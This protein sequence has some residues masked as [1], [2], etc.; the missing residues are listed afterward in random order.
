MTTSSE[1]RPVAAT[2][3]SEVEVSFVLACGGDIAGLV[4]ALT[5]ISAWSTANEDVSMELVLV[6]RDAH[7]L[8][9]AVQD[10]SGAPIRTLHV[11]APATAEE[12]LALGT[13]VAVGRELVSLAIGVNEAVVGAA[14]I[15]ESATAAKS[16]RV[17][18]MTR[19]VNEARGRAEWRPARW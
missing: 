19:S 5:Q 17:I 4:E 1:L 15:R 11:A 2:A 13:D 18:R 12:L 3:P 6:S 7:L 16:N 14:E 9:A 8:A 10:L